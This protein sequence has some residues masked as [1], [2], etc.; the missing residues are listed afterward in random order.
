MTNWVRRHIRE[1]VLWL[2]VFSIPFDTKKFIWSATTTVSE[3]HGI[4]IYGTDMLLLFFLVFWGAREIKWDKYS[5]LL[6]IFAGL[7]ILPALWSA[8][9]LLAVYGWVRLV[10][11]IA[12]ALGLSGLI[13]KKAV[14]LAAVFAALFASAIFQSIVALLQFREQASLGLKILGESVIGLTTPGIARVAAGGLTYLRSYGTM[15]HANILAAFLGFGLIAAIYLIYRADKPWPRL[16]FAAGFFVILAGL[17]FTFSRSG[18]IVAGL[19]LA[20]LLAYGLF[21]ESVRTKAVALLLILIAGLAFTVPSLGLLIFARAGFSSGEPSVADRVAY[22][23]IGLLKFPE[24]YPLGVGLKNQVL[25]AERNGWYRDFG[26]KYAFQEQP[27]HNIYLLMMAETG[28]L[29]LLVFAAF[30]VTLLY[31]RFRGWLKTKDGEIWFA[32]ALAGGALIFGLVDHFYWDLW[33]GQLMFWLALGILMGI[34]PRSPMDRMSP[35]EGEGAG[36][37]PAEGTPF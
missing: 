37:I 35:S 24:T 9:P 12:F 5:K 34:G 2:L 29:G 25:T 3:Y 27:I 4:F 32:L 36:S 31:E 26:L 19:A 17:T 15:P 28:V 7:A 11:V 18:W 14:G 30:I 10:L 21:K 6:A 13:R 20:A 16:G 8:T 1:I 33:S 23:E 22:D